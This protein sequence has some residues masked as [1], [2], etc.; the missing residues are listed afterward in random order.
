MQQVVLGGERPK[1]DSSHTAY[2][3]T[4]LQWLMKKCWSAFPCLRPDFILIKQVLKDIL[5]GSDSIPRGLEE[6]VEH[7]EERPCPATPPKRTG[8]F[9]ASRTPRGASVSSSV[10]P[11]SSKGVTTTPRGSISSPVGG[12]KG[13]AP[14]EKGRRARTWGFG[15]RR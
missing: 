14:P 6:D 8:F 10:T 1:M 4:N 7:M 12:F 15:T 2:W 3:P 13:M 5:K 9:R 11:S